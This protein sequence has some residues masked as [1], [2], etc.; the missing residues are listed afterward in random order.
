MNELH[1]V[2]LTATCAV[3]PRHISYIH[4]A[5]ELPSR[6]NHHTGKVDASKPAQLWVGVHDSRLCV[7][8]GDDAVKAHESIRIKLGI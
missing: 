6:V 5:D 4:L 2:E 8:S 1:L 3:D 7:A